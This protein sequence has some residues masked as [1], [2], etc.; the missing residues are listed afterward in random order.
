MLNIRKGTEYLLYAHLQKSVL[1]GRKIGIE[2][3]ADAKHHP[4]EKNQFW[5]C[6]RAK[7]TLMCQKQVSQHQTKVGLN[8]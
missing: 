5:Q 7:F 8:T 3:L 2:N 6:F 1:R 4:V